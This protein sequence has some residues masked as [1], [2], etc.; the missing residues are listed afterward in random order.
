M[1]YRRH[2][3][4]SGFGLDHAMENKRLLMLSDVLPTHN[5]TTIRSQLSR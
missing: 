1:G 4:L 5:V 2:E 3:E